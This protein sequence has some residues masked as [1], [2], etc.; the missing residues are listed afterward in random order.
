M[1]APPFSRRLPGSTP[2]GDV[3]MTTSARCSQDM[4]FTFTWVQQ[5]LLQGRCEAI[6]A[7]YREFIERVTLTSYREEQLVIHVLG[8]HGGQATAGKLPG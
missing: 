3:A 5:D 2:R 6:V 1:R 8:R 7:S 4:V